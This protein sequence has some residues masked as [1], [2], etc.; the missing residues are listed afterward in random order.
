VRVNA[1]RIGYHRRVRYQA[2]SAEGEL[3]SVVA[4]GRRLLA[5]AIRASWERGVLT[6]S[7]RALLPTELTVD[8]IEGMV[9]RIE[10]PDGGGAEPAPEVAP[11][12]GE[13]PALPRL[14]SL[15]EA[16][17]GRGAALAEDMLA[18]LLSIELDA[19]ARSLA[20]YLRGGAGSAITVGPLVLAVGE[21]RTPELLM[22]LGT[23]APLRRHRLVEVQDKSGELVAAATVRAAP[24][25]L[26]WLVDPVGLDDEVAEFATLH[27]PRGETDLTPAALAS[28]EEIIEGARLF[29][30]SQRAAR[31]SMGDLVLRGPRGSG[32]AEVAREACRRLK[33]PMLSAQL[34]ALLGQTNPGEAVAALLREALLLDAQLVLEGG[35]SLSAGDEVTQRVR[36]ALG[37]STRPLLVTSSNA[38]QSRL[39][40]GR[41]LVVR[42]VPIAPTHVRESIW[43]EVLP[44]VSASEVASLYR[45]GVGAIA[46]CADGARL[47]AEVRGSEV[48][49]HADVAQAV[50][51]EFETDLGTV[52]QRLDVSQTWEDLVVPDDTGRTIAE[53]VEQLRHRSTVLGR[54]G[55]QRKL[56]K[57]LG[58]T[59]LFSGEPGTGKSMVAGLIARELG[60]ELYQIDL[61]RVLSKWI[62][63]TEKNLAKV[64]DA[65]E[66]GHVVLLF[67]EADA[68]MGKRTAD[69]KSAN[70]RYANIETNYILQRL[71]QFHGVAILTSNL[72]S[73]IDPA[74]SRR[75]S[76]EL[77][78]PFPDEEQRVEI[79][80]RMLPVELPIVGEID[81]QKL[82]ARFELAGG[83]IRNIVLRAAY[84]AASDKTGMSMDHLMRA[85]EYEYRDHGMLVAKGRLS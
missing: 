30:E 29:L 80:K 24:R 12:S 75:L 67:D 73:S 78:F 82:A 14:G 74:L 38:E 20:S 59:A 64:F 50:R 44:E 58:T 18:V 69:V 55:F 63:E 79:W 61:S 65:A 56:G 41:K 60:L 3:K 42:E 26:R 83:H 17:A 22:A 11:V 85:A 72:E 33:L 52:A 35:E 23:G 2:Q 40:N 7:E 31:R 5:R 53:L 15:A 37:A 68:L 28:L 36:T 46:R 13:R 27:A 84:L 9:A 81:F 47:R 49:T 66:T 54:W 48:P 71:E 57:G 21:E 34:G 43:R 45:V 4:A 76:F 62:G 32:R 6:K 10:S 19:T 25:V 16:I 77:R 8:V 70:D 1:A 51:S 39:A